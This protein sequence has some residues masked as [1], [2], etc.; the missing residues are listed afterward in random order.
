MK[1]HM[2]GLLK[3]VGS[4][5]RWL[6]VTVALAL[7]ASSCVGNV[8]D[9][10][11][12]PPLGSA[13]SELRNGSLYNGSGVWRGA[14]G[15]FLW[16]PLWNEWQTCSGQV[17]SQRTILT[18]AHCVVRATSDSHA[19]G[20]NPGWAY[21]AVWRPSSTSSHVPVLTPQWVTGSYNPSHDGSSKYDVGL[22]VASGNLQNITSV[23]AGLLA[24]STPS[25]VNMY[26]IGFGDYGEGL[27]DDNGRMGVVTPTYNSTALEYYFQNTGSQPEIC[28]G[29]SGGPLKSTTSGPLLVYGVA[30]GNT[31]GGASCG[32]VGHW[33]T[34]ANNM[35][36]IRGRISGSCLETSTLY[37]CW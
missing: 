17:V 25:N 35:S 10:P 37:S 21:I 5:R 34:T 3:A 7:F 8:S 1:D 22:F 12:E 20:H 11:D 2:N 27:H 13:A 36:W 6:M 19:N 4:E 28:G 26:A 33:T 15:I 29:D 24:K 9:Q 14:V 30:H 18:A 31:G 32:P 16:S 23:D